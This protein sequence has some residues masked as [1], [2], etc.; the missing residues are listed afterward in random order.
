MN[1]KKWAMSLSTLV[2]RVLR[3]FPRGVLT[4]IPYSTCEA[5]GQIKFFTFPVDNL[6]P[7]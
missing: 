2:S 6:E 1:M 5:E 7:N 3:N 4:Q